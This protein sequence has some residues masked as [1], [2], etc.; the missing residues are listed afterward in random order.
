M[1]KIYLQYIY[2]ALCSQIKRRNF[3]KSANKSINENTKFKTTLAEVEKFALI[4]FKSVISNFWEITE[5]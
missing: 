3:Y 5:I 1:F 2:T 4:S